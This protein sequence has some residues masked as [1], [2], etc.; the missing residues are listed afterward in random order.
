MTLTTLN[1][2]P[3]SMKFEF[4]VGERVSAQF[5]DWALVSVSRPTKKKNTGIASL[6]C[7]AE[8]RNFIDRRL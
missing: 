2:A 6:E 5:W 8:N 4:G 1:F 7:K 3:L